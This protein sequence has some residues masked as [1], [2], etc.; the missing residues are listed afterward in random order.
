MSN[1]EG[2]FLVWL[3]FSKY[4]L[5]DNELEELMLLNAKVALDEGYMFGES[6]SGFERINV[7]CPRIILEKCM[8]NIEKALCRYF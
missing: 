4:L 7:A 5:T 2:T 8:L 6:G 1:P 3:D